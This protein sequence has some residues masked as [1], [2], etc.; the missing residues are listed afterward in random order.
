MVDEHD[1]LREEWRQI[2]LAL[3]NSEAFAPL[4]KKY[5]QKIFR[6]CYHKIGSQEDARDIAQQVFVKAMLNL[7]SFKNK[8]FGLSPWLY[9]IAFNE[10]NDWIK[11]KNREEFWI[12]NELVWAEMGVIQNVDEE[13]FDDQMLGTALT[14]LSEDSLELIRLRYFEKLPFAEVAEILSITESNA[15]VKVHRTINELRTYITKKN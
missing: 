5:I 10:I 12:N 7:K 8:G 2:E 11:Q 14:R 13:I 15:K 4:Y 9:K 6:Y 3:T 1:E